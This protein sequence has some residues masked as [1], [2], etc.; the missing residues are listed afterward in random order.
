MERKQCL[1]VMSIGLLFLVVWCIGSTARGMVASKVPVTQPHVAV[2]GVGQ[3][4]IEWYPTV[5]YDSLVLT[6]SGPDGIDFRQEFQTDEFPFFDYY[7]ENGNLRPDGLYVYGLHASPNIDPKTR[8]VMQAAAVTEDRSAVVERLK[9]EGK[10]P[11]KEL[12]QSGYFSFEGGTVIGGS[13]TKESAGTDS[14][15]SSVNKDVLHYDDVDITGSLCTGFDCKNEESFSYDTIRLKEHNLRIKFMDT[16]YTASYPRNDWQIRINS[17]LNGGQS[18][19]YIDDMGTNNDTE[20]TPDSTPF[21]IEANAPTNALYIEDYGRIGFGTNTPVVELHVKDSDTPTLRLEQ[22]SSGGWTAQT[23][24]VAGN[25]SNFFIRDV[26]AGSTLPFRIKPGAPSS[27]LCI[28]DDGNIGI[29][30]WSP[31]GSVHVENTAGD[32]EDDV[33][34][35]EDG[36][37]GIG[38][39]SPEGSLDVSGNVYMGDGDVSNRLIIRGNSAGVEGAQIDLTGGPGYA[40]HS[41]DTRHNRLRF[42]SNS[43]SNTSI[44]M[45]NVGAGSF[46]LGVG[47]TPV[48]NAL[49][50]EGDASKTTAGSWLANSDRR[51]KTDVRDVEGALDTINQLRPVVFRYTEEYRSQH[52]SIEDRDY[53]NYIA[54][55]YQEV[56]PE[57]VKDDGNGLL[58]MDG[59]NAAVVSVKAIQE[60]GG[61]LK[62]QQKA[63]R[64]LTERVMELESEDDDG[65]S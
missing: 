40:A 32:D 60:L 36:E 27:S 65:G 46:R 31:A 10:L 48:T 33:V 44:D 58:A 41:I 64:E 4:G 43:A 54:Q 19:F 13:K 47:R 2:M 12:V 22:D 49:E 28:V 14:D 50:V 62:E 29:G 34:I 35:T 53:Y 6:V 39:T 5:D 55:E 3:Y 45:Q 26:Q 18:A 30:T 20:Q 8:S 11:Q 24:D 9:Q 16:S 25:E 1:P 42:F 51:I 61:L 23:W 17:H 56:F 7:G 37:I 15:G 63:I 52:P 57:S 38:T 21:T 59:H